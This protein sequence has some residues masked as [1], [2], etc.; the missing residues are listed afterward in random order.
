MIW[1]NVEC[2]L[3]ESNFQ[4]DPTYKLEILFSKP[5]LVEGLVIIYSFILEQAERVTH[6]SQIISSNNLASCFYLFVLM[7][8]GKSG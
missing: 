3:N 2:E 4:N 8:V 7:F 5:I 6:E 1:W